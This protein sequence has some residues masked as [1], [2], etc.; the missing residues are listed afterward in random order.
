[1]QS[2]SNNSSRQMK[3]AFWGIVLGVGNEGTLKDSSGNN[4][5]DLEAASED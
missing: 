3:L 4:G 2:A 1:M 5:N